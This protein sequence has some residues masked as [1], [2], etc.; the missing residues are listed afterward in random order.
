MPQLD[1][2]NPVIEGYLNGLAIRRQREQDEIANQIRQ[3][4]STRQDQELGIKEKQFQ[5][6][7]KFQKHEM[8]L[9][10]AKAA[11]DSARL[12]MEQSQNAMNA[13]RQLYHD[14]QSGLQRMPTPG[15]ANSSPVGGVQV[16]DMV[17]DPR[18]AI[19]P[20]EAF[21]RKLEEQ[22]QLGGVQAETA[23]KTTSAQRTAEAPFKRADAEMSR[24]TEME[25]SRLKHRQELEQIGARGEVQKGLE[26]LQGHYQLEAAKLRQFANISSPED[27]EVAITPHILGTSASTLGKNSRDAL[28]RQA[29]TKSGFVEFTGAKADKMREVHGLDPLE[30]L[31]SETINKL[32]TDK[33]NAAGQ[34]LLAKLTPSDTK[35]LRGMIVSVAGQIAKTVGGESGRLTEDDI[36]RAIGMLVVPGITKEQALE[37]LEFFMANKRSK[38]MEGYLGAMGDKQQL[39]VLLKHKF[40]PAKYGG[41]VTISGNEMPRFIQDG[42]GEWRIADPKKGGYVKLDA[43]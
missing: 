12:K 1:L 23:G 9:A 4:E 16:G 37:R 27:Y 40:D 7:L 28:L 15:E 13:K 25:M 3:E 34:H 39:M 43:K 8:D 38:V 11:N 33:L 30:K 6:Y 20:Q 19:S 14:L 21:Q 5:Q 24:M 29:I 18:Q 31:M 17:I 26:N 41:V 35:N 22:R 10:D 2:R 42:D 32:S 36:N